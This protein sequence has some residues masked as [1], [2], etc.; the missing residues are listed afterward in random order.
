MI[1]MVVLPLPPALVAVTVYVVMVDNAVG[2]PEIVPVVVSK[3]RP[4]GN[5]GLIDQLV[6]APPV[7]VGLQL[8][9]AVLI[10]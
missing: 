3:D 9:I 7:L 10:T 5:D 4:A 8:V 2:V 6:A 1:L